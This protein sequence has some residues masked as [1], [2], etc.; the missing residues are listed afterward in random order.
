MDVSNKGVGNINTMP[1]AC[2]RFDPSEQERT[3]EL[4]ES[5]CLADMRRTIQTIEMEKQ[6]LSDWNDKLQCVVRELEEKN[7]ETST[8]FNESE[9]RVQFLMDRV[10]SLLSTGESKQ[11][12]TVEKMLEHAKEHTVMLDNLQESLQMIRGQNKE[13]A[14]RLSEEQCL[15]ARLHEQLCEAQNLFF[16]KV[17]G[18][19]TKPAIVR[20]PMISV[21]VHP[22][23][24]R[25]VF[26]ASPREKKWPV[27]HSELSSISEVPTPVSERISS[28][29]K[30]KRDTLEE[31]NSSNTGTRGPPF[32]M[33]LSRLQ[34]VLERSAP[35][36]KNG[37]LPAWPNTVGTNGSNDAASTPP[38][39]P[40]SAHLR[41]AVERMKQKLHTPES[42][43]STT[44][45][46]K[47]HGICTP[48]STSAPNMQYVKQPC[49]VPGSTTHIDNVKEQPLHT[50][51]KIESAQALV[52]APAASHCP[53]VESTKQ[54]YGAADPSGLPLETC[55]Q[56]DPIRVPDTD[57]PIDSTEKSSS[58]ASDST[59]NPKFECVKQHII[60]TTDGTMP[61]IESAMHGVRFADISTVSLRG[62]QEQPQI[63]MPDATI[64]DKASAEH[65][66]RGASHRVNSTVDSAKQPI[67]APELTS[68]IGSMVQPRRFPA[69]SNVQI[70][71][72]PE[73]HL[74]GVPDTNSRG[75]ESSEQS[76]RAWIPSTNSKVESMGQHMRAVDS[77][78]S[79]VD[80]AKQAVCPPKSNNMY[81]THIGYAKKPSDGRA[82]EST[83]HINY[84]VQQALR[85]P[86]PNKKPQ[87]L[88]SDPPTNPQTERMK[89]M[90]RSA[91]PN[92]P[93]V[94]PRLPTKCD[95]G[96]LVQQQYDTTQQRISISSVNS[97]VSQPTSVTNSPCPQEPQRIQLVLPQPGLQGSSIQPFGLS[98][99]SVAPW[100]MA[101]QASNRD[102]SP[103][104]L[105]FK[106]PWQGSNSSPQR[107]YES[108]KSDVAATRAPSQPQGKF[109]ARKITPPLANCRSLLSSNSIIGGTT[110]RPAILQVPRAS[111]LSP[112]R[113]VNSASPIRLGN[114]LT[115]P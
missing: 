112:I 113:L 63:R 11:Q 80:S 108:P 78:N 104:P 13:L 46:A 84:M 38:L 77:N 9:T 110:L 59:A 62:A 99:R 19:T 85:A 111:S 50:T 55:A 2:Q 25:P 4:S 103:K 68:H 48:D 54:A 97:N 36:T 7:R 23:E 22:R 94:S 106:T 93:L 24:D 35:E 17:A 56:H 21:D 30:E 31:Q 96:G 12:A 49:G 100:P 89:Q 44:D 6:N 45:V 79:N 74:N 43:S 65:Q 83:A 40:T 3:G 115:R 53:Q 60:R 26:P 86:Y 39:D 88:S 61:H 75:T 105:Q 29:Q 52:R 107:R 70:K 58:S 101:F 102:W 95:S 5:D 15:S 51:A 42:S 82:P 14:Q 16:S 67:R 91:E 90:L 71:W 20:P 87:V 1:S 41:S 32:C 109:E 73:Q 66:L 27:G 34:A 92:Q 81:N 98:P 114:L 64:Q 33:E 8:S 28:P 18:A 47:Q 57:A 10:V 69:P 76:Q 72:A 37:G